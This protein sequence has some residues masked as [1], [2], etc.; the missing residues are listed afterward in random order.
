LRCLIHFLYH[1][2]LDRDVW[3]RFS[4]SRHFA[5][6]ENL[7]GLYSRMTIDDADVRVAPGVE[8]WSSFWF[9]GSCDMEREFMVYV[10]FGS[11]EL[12]I[13]GWIPASDDDLMIHRLTGR[14]PGDSVDGWSDT[15]DHGTSLLVP[16]GESACWLKA[17]QEQAQGIR[18][19]DPATG[20]APPEEELAGEPLDGVDPLRISNFRSGPVCGEGSGEAGRPPSSRICQDTDIPIRGRDT[21]VFNEVRMPCTWWGFEFDYEDA[22]PDVPLA[23]TWRRSRPGTEGNWEGLRSQGIETET[24]RIDLGDTAGHT[25]FPAFDIH[26]DDIAWP[27]IDV[28][29]TCSYG[30]HRAFSATHRLLFSSQAGR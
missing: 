10:T 18:A 20:C 27:V 17:H 9:A 12:P 22:Q 29:F 6:V 24:I 14:G 26:T 16:L 2:T 13:G 23:C 19:T 28:E 30:G 7:V 4:D 3:I 5:D 11:R 25:F 1:N 8:K 21:C 15:G